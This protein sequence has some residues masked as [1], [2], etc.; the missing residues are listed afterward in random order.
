MPGV[1]LGAVLPPVEALSGM[2]PFLVSLKFWGGGREYYF[3]T[4][5]ISL[6]FPGPLQVVQG[7]I[8]VK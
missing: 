2:F 7:K 1:S 6:S 8:S 5:E 4:T 3:L